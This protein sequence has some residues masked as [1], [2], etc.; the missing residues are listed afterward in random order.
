MGRADHDHVADR[1]IRGD[2]LIAKDCTLD[3][4]G[5]ETVTGDIDDIVGAAVQREAAVGILQREVALRVGEPA[6][7]TCPVGLAVALEV[8]TPAARDSTPLDAELALIAPD[9][10]AQIGERRGDHDFAF[11]ADLSRTGHDGA[12]AIRFAVG[13]PDIACDPG[14][15]VGVGVGAQREVAVAEVVRPDDAAVLG[16]P[17][18]VDVPGGHELHAELLHHRRGRLGAEGRDA[19]RAARVRAHILDVL[20]IGHH[21]LKEGDAGLEYIDLVA[22]DD[23]GEAARAGEHRC[24]LGDDGGHA[25]GERTA[26]HVALAGD[27]AWVGDDIHDIARTGVEGDAHGVRDT[28]R[29]AAV[30][31]HHALGLARRTGGVDKEQRELGVERLRRHRSPQRRDQRGV[32]QREQRVLGI[33][34]ET[35]G[36]RCGEDLDGGGVGEFVTP[37]VPLWPPQ[38]PGQRCMAYHDNGVDPRWHGHQRRRDGGADAARLSGADAGLRLERATDA[39]HDIRALE[40]DLVRGGSTGAGEDRLGL[41]RGEPE[42]GQGAGHSVDRGFGRHIAVECRVRIGFFECHDLGVAVA[43]VSGDHHAR[44]GVMDAVGERLV[45]EAAEHRR[46]DEAEPLAGFCPVELLRD[47]RQ[48]DGDAVADRETE[49]PQRERATHRLKQQ[50]TARHAERGHRT[51]AAAVEGLV[52]AI[53]LEEE[54]GL[55]AVPGEHMPIYFIEAGVGECAVEPAVEGRI[56]RIERGAPRGVVGRERRRDRCRGLRIPPSPVACGGVERQ[57]GAVGSDGRFEPVQIAARVFSVVGTGVAR[58]GITGLLPRRPRGEG[59]DD[60]RR[61]GNSRQRRNRFHGSV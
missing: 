31:M 59:I 57:P 42:R 24:T 35:G 12:R 44:T 21:G 53:T 9:G 10:A 46:V 16:R 28:R 6:L 7:P 55:L 5:A 56:A 43:A 58:T 2:L 40:R 20:G 47:V 34:G 37:A 4:L 19:Q 11:F 23:T 52:P 48:V 50:P 15:R 32:G 38:Q 61:R 13:D 8:A 26:V 14:Q 49:T 39:A 60:G 27:P 29:P 22:L 33:Y 54:R 45:A 41:R 25:R 1:R 36:A 17:I 3:L 18:G 51:A 30:H